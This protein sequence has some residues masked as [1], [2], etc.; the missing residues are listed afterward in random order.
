[1][2]LIY[3]FVFV[4][5]G[6]M[7]YSSWTQALHPRSSSLSAANSSSVRLK[8]KIC[9]Q[10]YILLAVVT[11]WNKMVY[12]SLFSYFLTLKK[13]ILILFGYVSGLLITKTPVKIDPSNTIWFQHEHSLGNSGN[14]ANGQ[15]NTDPL[16]TLRLNWSWL[17]VLKKA[18]GWGR[19]QCY[20]SGWNWKNMALGQKEAQ[21]EGG[22]KEKVVTFVFSRMWWALSLLG[23]TDIPRCTW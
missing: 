11:L 10:Q 14:I 21:N 3:L 17:Y 1:M 20:H 13:F 19:H 4:C 7:S 16:C 9:V 6:T 2:S 5:M 23:M 18:K 12:A 8:S 15:R 22:N